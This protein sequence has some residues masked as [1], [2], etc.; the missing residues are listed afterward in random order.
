MIFLRFILAAVIIFIA[1][2]KLT[3]YAEILAEKWGITHHVMGFILLSLIT[4]LPE[5]CASSTAAY[6]GNADLALGN[7]FGSNFFNIFIIVIL[8]F[9]NHRKPIIFQV[10]KT[11]LYT[12]RL[13]IILVAIAILGI[14][15][16]NGA[17]PLSISFFSHLKLFHIGLISLMIAIVY[18]WGA[19]K[20]FRASQGQQSPTPSVDKKDI[21]IKFT[22]PKFIVSAV[23]I[24][25][26]GIYVSHLADH[27]S[28]LSFKGTVLGG[29]LVGT[30]LLAI[31]TSL[32]ELAVT[33]SAVKKGLCS[34]A[35]GNILG[36]N[37][38]NMQNIFWADIF[39][40]PGTIFAAVSSLHIFTGSLV[41]LLTLIVAWGIVKPVQK[42]FFKI[43]I[44]TL[45]ILITY[46]GGFYLIF[47]F[48]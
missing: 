45:A 7:L 3:K 44:L 6:I 43:N 40:C 24:I 4:A 22:L 35:L 13:G 27:I 23:I 32:P 16:T 39:Y 25:A 48:R 11:L 21:S 30:F 5:L 47:K 15:L 9:L 33:T 10:E 38:V 31:A 37:L 19:K 34:M 18:F 36:S 28:L 14:V 12:A 20:I 2:F 1:A 17:T 41:I 42:T 26:T 29:T 46:F 8:D